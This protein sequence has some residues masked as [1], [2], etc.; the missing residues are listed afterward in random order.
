[1]PQ[2]YL[3]D[4]VA[5][6]ALSSL[7]KQ[8]GT[9]RARRTPHV[10]DLQ[11]PGLSGIP[12]LGGPP[13][14]QMPAVPQPTDAASQ[15]EGMSGLQQSMNALGGVQISGSGVSRWAPLV[16]QSAQQY[17]VNDPTFNRI[18]LAV[19][20]AESGGNPMA[21]GDNGQSLGLYQ[22]NDVH[23]IPAELRFNPQFNVD[24]AVQRLADAYKSARAAGLSGD[25]LVR[26]VYNDAINP[27]GGYGYQGNSVVRW[28]NGMGGG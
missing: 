23:G 10:R 2:Q 3:T 22:L 24:W 27:G 9:P 26:H 15:L 4:S 21:A 13:G 1:M 19:M 28:Y 6:D 16:Q 7:L 20:G 12:G 18:A 17:G 8:V 14:L 5:E 25:A 11:M